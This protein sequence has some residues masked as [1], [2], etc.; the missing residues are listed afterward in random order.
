MLNECSHISAPQS[1][2]SN[3]G[4]DQHN[5]GRDLYTGAHQHIAGRDQQIQ[6]ININIS[7]TA[8]QETVRHVLC[9]LGHFSQQPPRPTS[10]LVFTSPDHSPCNVDVAAN[11]IV[12]I[13]RSLDDLTKYSV[14]YRYLHGLLFEPLHQV[15]F[16][17]GIAI[18]VYEDTPLGPNLIAGISP[19]VKQCCVIL[20]D[21]RNS[22][23]R[24]M[25]VLYSTPIRALWP[26]VLWSSSTVHDLVWKLWAHQRSLG[27]FLV[28]LNS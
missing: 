15:L 25:R 2:F 24:Y 3:V 28:A 11:L 23:D 7:D 16:L 4:H 5:V 13:T 9:N 14:D 6:T 18:Q 22:I 27:E 17:I 10:P 20:Q 26:Q 12:E 19:A 21:I 1:H 8:S